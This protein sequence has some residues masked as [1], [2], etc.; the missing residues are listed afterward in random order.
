MKLFNQHELD[1][2]NSYYDNNEIGF[3]DKS[4][5][6]YK[7]VIFNNKESKIVD[8]LLDWFELE[9][10]EK[11]KN[12]DSYLFLHKYEIGD[13]FTKHKDEAVIADKHREYV[14][15]FHIND[16]YE[17]GEYRLYNPES[18]IDKTSGV[19]YFF[20]ANREHEI[21]PIINGIRKS[22]LM[23]IYSEDLHKKL[24]MI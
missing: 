1:L 8:K 10:G 17:G 18:I 16:D 5:R 11:I 24:R 23:F 4:D 21:T 15:G 3:R 7:F 20:R 2:V 12:R 14:V 6:S 22:A 9:S 13:Y 19:P